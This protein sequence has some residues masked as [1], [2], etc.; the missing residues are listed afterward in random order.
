M[1]A[2][3]GVVPVDLLA[4]ERKRIY[5]FSKER[6]RARASTNVRTETLTAWQARWMDGDKG[7][8]TRRL[9]TDVGL[10]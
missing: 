2:I 7:K 8:W 10:W 4:L 5:E 1:L 9:I 6:G 3:A